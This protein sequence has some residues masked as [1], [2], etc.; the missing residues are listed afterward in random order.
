MTPTCHPER[1]YQSNGLCSPCYTVARRRGVGTTRMAICHPERSD[2][3]RGKCA[4]C[5]EAAGARARRT[6]WPPE[7]LRAWQDRANRRTRR[8]A[9]KKLGLTEADYDAL[10]EAQGGRCGICGREPGD[11]MLQLDHDHATLRPRGLLCGDCNRALGLL[12][13]DIEGVAAALQYLQRTE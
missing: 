2:Y 5:Y 4:S 1:K 9:L 13:D 12:G 10:F 8:W 6:A 3:A 7:R 11:A